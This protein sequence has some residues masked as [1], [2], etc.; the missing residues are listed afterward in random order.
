M[1]AQWIL[2]NFESTPGAGESI[3]GNDTTL[4]KKNIL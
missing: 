1:E 2:Y 3:V 4:L